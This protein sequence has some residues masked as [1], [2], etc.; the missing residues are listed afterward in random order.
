MGVSIL[1]SKLPRLPTRVDE[2]QSNCAIFHKRSTLS[3]PLTICCKTC[4]L[5]GEMSV[6]YVVVGSFGAVI[7]RRDVHPGNNRPAHSVGAIVFFRV[8]I[9]KRNLFSSCI[10]R[11]IS[12]ASD[13]PLHNFRRFTGHT[14]S[15]WILDREK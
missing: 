6:S 4:G 7:D 13:D 2:G 10:S 3:R 8:L 14:A 15:Q 5:W 9:H 12:Q 1:D 11:I